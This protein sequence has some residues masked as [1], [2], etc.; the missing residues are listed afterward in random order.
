MANRVIELMDD[1]H[2]SSQ[3]TFMEYYNA[4]QTNN[5]SNAT[6]ILK[7]NPDVSNQIINADNINILLNETYRR[8]L[9]PKI[10]IDYFLEG[11]L[12]VY[13]K[14]IDFTKVMGEWDKDTQ[15]NVHNFVYY[16]GKGYYAYTNSTPP[17]G[18]LPTDEN[19]WIEY[20][21]KGLQGYGGIDLNFKFNWDNTQSYKKGDVVIY[22]NKMWYAIADNN[23]YEPNLN[24]YPWVVISMPKLPAKTPIQRAIPTGYDIGDFWFQ[25]TQ[26]DEVIVTTWGIR[27]AEPTPRFA[28]TAFSINN[29]VYIV[30]GINSSFERVTTNEAFDTVL[31]TWSVK[32]P[33]GYTR[34]RGA[35]FSIGTMGHLVGG[36]SANGDVQNTHYTYDSEK[37]IWSTAKEYPIPII[38]QA[39][40]AN[41]IAYIIGG[42][43][44]GNVLTGKSYSY[45]PST[46][47]WE[48]ITDKPTLTQGHTVAT[49]GDNI[50]AI[51]GIDNNDNTVGINEAYN[52]T[53]KAWSQKDTLTVPRSYLASFVQGG[54][55]YAIGGLNSNWYSVDTNE[56]YDIEN[57]QWI[58]DMPMNYKRSS[59]NAIVS[60]TRAFA[61][62]GIDFANSD[63]KGY[64]EQ[65]N[66]DDMPSS[67]EMVVDTSLDTTGSK[68]ISI[69]MI[70][71]GNYNYYVD[72]GDGL[73]ST[74]ITA[75]NDPQASHTYA[76]DGEYTVKLIGTLDRLQFNQGTN[77]ATDLKSVTKCILNFNTIT[78][79]FEGCSNLESICDGI[80]DQSINITDANNTF[81][82]CT[83]LTVIP[84][85]LFDN[86]TQ[87]Q[88]FNYTFQNTSITNIPTDLFSS[89]NLASTFVATFYKCSKLVSIPS[90]L[91][92]NNANVINF[93][94]VFAD[95]TSLSSIPNNLFI[96]NPMVTNYSLSFRGCKA[97]TSLPSNLF[98]N[99]NGSVTNYSSTFAVTGL[100]S[101]PEGLFSSAQNATTYNNVFQSCPITAIPN[102]CFNGNNA[103][104]TG[105]FD[106]SKITTIG[107]N[108]LKGLAVPA[109]FFENCTS[110]VSAGN[111]IFGDN[112]R[113]F[114]NMFKN[115]SNL[116]TLGNID[117]SRLGSTAAGF[118]GCTKLTN[119]VGFRDRETGTEPTISQSFDIASTTLLTRDS[120]LNLVDSLK[121]LTPTTIKNL[122]LSSAARN[123]LTTVEK[124][125]VIN[126]YWN[127]SNYNPTSDITPEISNELVQELYGNTSTQAQSYLETGLYYYVKLITSSSSDLLGVYA[128]DKA[129]GL[130]Y[131]KDNVPEHEYYIKV[132]TNAEGTEG[133]QE[134]WLAKGSNDDID[135]D[136]L[137]NKLSELNGSISL[138][139]I[140]LGKED[141]TLDIDTSIKNT[142]T[143]LIDLCNGFSNLRT[144]RLSGTNSSKA[145]S[146]VR[147]FNNCQNLSTIDFGNIAFNN[148]TY[149]TNA[150]DNCNSLSNLDLSKFNF[151]S[152]D[153]LGYAFNGC[154]SLQNLTLPSTVSFNNNTDTNKME[155]VFKNCSSLPTTFFNSLSNWTTSNVS[156]MSN[157]FN[158]CVNLT[159]MPTFNMQNVTDTSYMFAG[160]GLTNLT[161]NI[162]GN[163]L[164]DASYMFNNCNNLNITGISD[165][166]TIFGHNDVLTNVKGLFAGCDNLKNVGIHNVFY[167]DETGGFPEYKIDENKINN[168]LFTYCPNIVDM[169]SL[170]TGCSLVGSDVNN[171]DIPMGL[172]YHC[173]KVTNISH[174]FDGCKNITINQ[175]FPGLNV[176]Y[177]EVLFKNNPELVNVSYAF[178]NAKTDFM[179]ENTANPNLL[180]PVQTKIEDASY[181]WYK[182]EMTAATGYETIPFIYKSKVVKN[183]SNMFKGQTFSR[184]ISNQYDSYNTQYSWD[185][186]QNIMPNLENCS[187][188]FDGNTNLEGNALP[189][190]NSL[191]QISTLTNHTDA[192]NA[193]S[194]LT[195]YESIPA[196][197]K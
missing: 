91:F 134:I 107:D 121:T 44:T 148:V 143:G 85:G 40:V 104:I 133:V 98:G 4:M 181:L 88:Y 39:A 130:V 83:A 187:E 147:M 15:Y 168:Q 48:E 62:G 94:S 179:G 6:N 195:D 101:I 23:N 8:E 12:S 41:D 142:T 25:I 118:A 38:S 57:N 183:I 27:Q 29:N 131:L 84:L 72:W 99:S 66:I 153:N 9:I 126:K 111:N 24:H 5:I 123:K 145:A 144:F 122:T 132:A 114:A 20:D 100:T 177:T 151:N 45:N 141:D 191:K 67:F 76:E 180:F 138:A 160:S 194:E 190:I 22:Q 54:I 92:N 70:D 74:K 170:L 21:I 166:T 79:L 188:L 58:T 189:M 59:L 109:G 113:S 34:V 124:L 171:K 149:Y 96:N 35:G 2:L 150:F 87:I 43:T 63:I 37:N 11:L 120:L 30:G 1:M 140:Q 49:D 95:C 56:K 103:D 65:Y 173:P 176:L 13:Q 52:I 17:I 61:I 175:T 93:N 161:A 115:C 110:L 14:M 174:I 71:G 129:T 169:S 154:S 47:T 68:Q 162:L 192:F 152:V 164:K 117:F 112:V 51:G 82:D 139:Y 125:K 3:G 186:I 55:I 119:L 75:Y 32:Q 60:G 165:Y 156:S 36:Q 105:A 116:T 31:G 163:K 146:I 128:V 102:N 182:C 81:K 7:N 19:Y 50:Y 16:N 78:S 106:V 42:E 196:D 53:S 184:N 46:N 69:P 89:N 108:A 135:G 158:G 178:A 167:V 127:I 197:W 193:C 136:I 159:T 64:N 18:T 172:L 33:I 155:G 80:F 28:S 185:N 137:D 26:G 10:D 86:N 97:L 90:G 73:T 77:I 157:I